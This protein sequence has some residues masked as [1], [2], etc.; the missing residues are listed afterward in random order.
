MKFL[1]PEVTAFN[2]KEILSKSVSLEISPL[3]RIN[4]HF[5]NQFRDIFLRLFL[6]MENV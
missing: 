1:L 5:L 4:Q 3:K 6:W 2:I